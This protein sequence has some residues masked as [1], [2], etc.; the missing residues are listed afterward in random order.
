M[1]SSY[2]AHFGEE[3]PLVGRGGSGAIFFTN[4]TMRCVFC[5]N[6]PIS[7]QGVGQEYT[8]DQLANMYLLL[9]KRGCEN[10]NFVTPTHLLPQILMALEIAVPRG[11]KLPL[12]YNTSGYECV[13]IVQLLDGIFDIYLPDIKYADDEMALKYSGVNDYVENNRA[14]LKEMYRQV[15]ELECD[16]RGAARRGLIVRHLVL[17]EGISGSEESLRWMAEHLSPNIH[18]ALMSQYFPA[19]EAPEIPEIARR[20]KGSEYRPLASLHE[21]LGFDGWIQPTP[22]FFS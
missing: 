15:G 19:Y 22:G 12:V 10:I 17:P 21:E 13:E 18:V 1:V 5:Q 8:I 7:Q 3:P 16:E 4:C 2:N 11:F 20:V 14:S 9:Q 6:Y